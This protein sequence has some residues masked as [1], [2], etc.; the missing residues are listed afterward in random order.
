MTRPNGRT[1]YSLFH[2]LKPARVGS[3]RPNIGTASRRGNVCAASYW[4]DG[5]PNVIGSRLW[6]REVPLG[7]YSVS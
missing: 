2:S 5:I 4:S 6:R 1:R 3:R 7:V